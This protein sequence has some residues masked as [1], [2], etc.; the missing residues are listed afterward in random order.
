MFRLISGDG[1]VLFTNANLPV[2]FN[3]KVPKIVV[4]KYEIGA[5]FPSQALVHWIVTLYYQEDLE[6]GVDD[7]NGGSFSRGEVREFP[8]STTASVSKVVLTLTKLL[9]NVARDSIATRINELGF[10][11]CSTEY[12]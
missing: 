8:V 12:L 4:T 9:L 3:L 10:R 1:G 6:I 11:S 5:G 7:Q 2:T